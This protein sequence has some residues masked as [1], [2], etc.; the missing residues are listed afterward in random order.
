M[1]PGGAEKAEVLEAITTFFVFLLSVGAG[2]F[3]VGCAAAAILHFT[4]V[5][6]S[7]DGLFKKSIRITLTRASFVIGH[8]RYAR[9]FG[10]DFRREDHKKGMEEALK[11]QRTGIRQCT[12][13]RRAVEVVMRYGERRIVIAAFDK[14]NMDDAG[15]LV[16]RL[17]AVHN[18]F[19]ELMAMHGGNRTGQ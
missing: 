5:R 13:Y 17:Q 10:P 15:A 9:H 8:C 14:N 16:L 19:D 3:L 4:I 6:H 11:E 18:N 2:G 1:V 12:R 7:W